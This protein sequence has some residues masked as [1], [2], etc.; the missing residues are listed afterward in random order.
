MG[1]AV[2][3][4][5]ERL[6]VVDSVWRVVA[7]FDFGESEFR[8]IGAGP[9]N[10]VNG[11][12]GVALDADENVY[13]ADTRAKLV[14]VYS[15]DGKFLRDI[16]KQIL[17]RPTGVAVNSSLGR[18]YVVDGGRGDW[19][20]GHNIKLFD[21][22][23]NLIKEVGR[24]GNE[25]GMLSFPTYATLDDQGRLYVVDSANFRVQV[26]DPEGN[27]LWGFGRPGDQMGEFSRAKAVALDTFGNIYVVD[28]NWNNVQIFN[29]E[30][31]L[32]LFFGGKGAAVGLL[33]SPAGIAIDKNNKIYVA[34]SFGKG[35]NM[36]QLVNT[37]AADAIPVAPE[38]Q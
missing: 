28:S 26:F 24:R 32:L 15:R 38:D 29:Q 12:L 18:V 35:V 11:P 25:S 19:Q 17:V 31:T 21:L 1:L 9:E 20:R 7:V 13:V 27:F 22:E 34:D 10:A 6:Y 30:G 4:D 2:S 36:Y 16:G 3:E 14:R 33:T 8:L 23:G 5:G 37:T